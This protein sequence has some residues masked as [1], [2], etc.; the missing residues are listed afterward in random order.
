MTKTKVKIPNIILANA[1]NG[2]DWAEDFVKDFIDPQEIW[3]ELTER[4]IAKAIVS[5]SGGG[6]KPSARS[7]TGVQEI[8]Y[9]LK[10]GKKITVDYDP[11][12]DEPNKGVINTLEYWLVRVL[13]N[14]IDFTKSCF[15]AGTLTY[16]VKN[17]QILWQ[18]EEED[19]PLNSFD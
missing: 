4:N 11:K 6:E 14:R 9:E 12:W 7:E 16:D 8:T 5:F 10:N 2:I 15:V 17:R 3:F 1:M 19:L 13:Y 18:M